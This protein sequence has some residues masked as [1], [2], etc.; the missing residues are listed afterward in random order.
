MDDGLVGQIGRE[1]LVAQHLAED[2]GNVG[3]GLE[4][5][6]R[7]RGEEAADDSVEPQGHVGPSELERRPRV[8]GGAADGFERRLTCERRR[9][10][11][12]VVERG[13]EAIQVRTSVGP[14]RVFGLLRGNVLRRPEE[15]ARFRQP[16]VRRVSGRQERPRDAEVEELHPC[17]L[18]ARGRDDH[19]VRRLHIAVDEAAIVNVLQPVGRLPDVLNGLRPRQRA[20]FADEPYEVVPRDVLQYEVRERRVQPGV[21][22]ADDVRVVQ[23]GG[24]PGLALEPLPHVWVSEGRGGNHLQRHDAIQGRL[25]GAVDDAHAPLAQHLQHL[26]AGDHDAGVGVGRGGGAERVGGR[27]EHGP[28][29]GRGHGFRGSPGTRTRS[30]SARTGRSTGQSPATPH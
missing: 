8:G 19:Y 18:P 29:V 3:R 13:P 10:G 1:G 15:H 16:G 11:E 4:S 9:P 20:A 24:S 5:T 22:Q 7:V 14:A 17:R 21:I 28:R 6:G 23:S 2:V 12:E 30:E 26:E 27:E 25:A